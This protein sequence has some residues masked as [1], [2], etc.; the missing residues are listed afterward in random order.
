M[1]SNE[2]KITKTI[3]SA[4]GRVLIEQP[5]GSYRK[6]AG[7]TDWDKVDAMREEDIER[8]AIEDMQELGI[9]PDWMK[10][11]K[12]VYPPHKER[13][14]MRLDADLVE[15]FKQQGRGYQT[16]INAILRSYYESHRH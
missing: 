13:I 12:P 1:Q 14:T 6:T 16:R 9:D 3:L 5:D 11:A 7:E 15:W 2:E 8:L 10:H 4:D